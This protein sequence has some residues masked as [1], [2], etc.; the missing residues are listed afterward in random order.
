[1]RFGLLLLAGLFVAA[2][3]GEQS[4]GV[5]IELNKLEQKGA[6]C[7]L[8]MLFKNRDARAFESLKLDLVAF[9]RQSIVSQRLA[10]EGGPLPAEKT[11][12]KAFELSAV[13]CADLSRLLLNGVLACKTGGGEATDCLQ[14]V[15]TSSRTEVEFIQ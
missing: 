10:L 5:A 7:R 6:D 3:H 9:D 2:A 13:Q 8:Y 15:R 4:Q 11:L 12:L 14:R 1:M